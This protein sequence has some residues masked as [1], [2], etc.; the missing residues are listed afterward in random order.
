MATLINKQ[1][2]V[3]L[4]KPSRF[5]V[6]STSLE[7]QL[8]ETFFVGQKHP[9]DYSPE[10]RKF[11]KEEYDHDETSVKI[12]L[13]AGCNEF[14][15]KPGTLSF[16]L[17]L[18]YLKEQRRLSKKSLA[19]IVYGAS[20]VCRRGVLN[21][22]INSPYKNEFQF[23]IKK[24]QGI[25]LIKEIS[26]ESYR[27]QNARLSFN[28][29]FYLPKFKNHIISPFGN[30][31]YLPPK[32]VSTWEQMQGVYL[33]EISSKC[34]SIPLKIF[35][36]TEIDAF[37]QENNVVE[38][39]LQK[40]DFHSSPYMAD[41]LRKWYFQAQLSNS[42]TIVVGFRSDNIVNCIKKIKTHDLPLLV[43]VENRWHQF[44]SYA[45]T[46]TILSSI[47]EF[48]EKHVKPN[49]T[50]I[51]EMPSNGSNILYHIHDDKIEN[52]LPKEFKD[53]FEETVTLVDQNAKPSKINKGYVLRTEKG[54]FD[55]NIE[56]ALKI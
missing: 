3:L 52:M 41:K 4:Q 49:E 56:D 22:L 36:G 1:S 47:C 53:V 11:V 12:D 32:E 10:F 7:T 39:K 51:V 34:D 17:L 28:S 55:E 37:D 15:E 23:A 16:D 25:Y 9:I 21:K 8:V 35:Y 42:D 40:G 13:T 46:K 18:D 27:Q 2:G 54:W 6:T 50:L 20:I 5:N 33:C 24:F 29:H 48:Y 19:E 14:L 44:P 30:E 38:I 43:Q 26:T 31:S 45:A